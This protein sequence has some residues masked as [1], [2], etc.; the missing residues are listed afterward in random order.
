MNIES[1][2]ANPDVTV[3]IRFTINGFSDAISLTGEQAQKLTDEQLDA[4]KQVRYDTWVERVNT[5]GVPLEVTPAS[6]LTEAQTHIA[7][8]NNTKYK[9]LDAGIVDD[10]ALGQ[11]IGTAIPLVNQL[12]DAIP[13]IRGAYLASLPQSE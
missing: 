12:V 9:I 8:L 5:P 13:V 6:L 11:A 1:L 2:L 7:N 3:H 10:S 4:M